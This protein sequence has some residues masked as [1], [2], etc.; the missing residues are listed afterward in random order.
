MLFVFFICMEKLYSKKSPPVSFHIILMSNFCRSMAS[1]DG[2]MEG[3]TNA[4]SNFTVSSRSAFQPSVPRNAS[5]N[6]PTASRYFSSP[7]NNSRTSDNRD[8]F[9]SVPEAN[10]LDDTPG[11]SDG[12]GPPP[13]SLFR[14][15]R[16]QQRSQ[17]FETDLN[18]AVRVIRKLQMVMGSLRRVRVIFLSNQ[19]S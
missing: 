10:F 1:E 19:N 17:D 14:N 6:S 8:S 12:T 5:Y 18:R 4:A 16:L 9:S 7:P 3:P 13:Y 11:P 15:A 2:Y